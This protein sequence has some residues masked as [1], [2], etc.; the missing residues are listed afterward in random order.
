[1][2]L[3]KMHL[4]IS[5]LCF[6]TYFGVIITCKSILKEKGWAFKKQRFWFVI[7]W[8]LNSIIFCMI[9]VINI[10]MAIMVVIMLGISKKEWDNITSERRKK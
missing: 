6:I 4:A 5:V 8:S 9:P 1:M 3:L 7:T 10:F 2:W